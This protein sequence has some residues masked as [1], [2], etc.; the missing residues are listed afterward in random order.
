MLLSISLLCISQIVSAVLL[1]NETEVLAYQALQATAS[2]PFLQELLSIQVANS[3]HVKAIP[4]LFSQQKGVVPSDG[5]YQ[6]PNFGALTSWD[7]ILETLEH[8]ADQRLLILI[9]HGQ[10]YENL[11]PTSNSNCEFILDGEIIQNFDSPLSPEGQQQVQ[12]LND[13]FRSPVSNSSDKTWFETVGLAQ[14]TSNF[15]TSPLSRTMQTTEGAFSQLPLPSGQSFQ[16]HELIR[17]SVGVDVCNFRHSVKTPTSSDVLPAPWQTGCQLPS[18]SLESLF[19][20]SPKVKFAFSVR[21]AGGTGFGL[22]SDND[23][24][25]RSDV[26]D[27]AVIN[28]RASAFLSQVF[29]YTPASSVT[30]VV[31]H[32]EMISAIYEAAGEIPYSAKNTQVVPLMLRFHA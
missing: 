1:A 4:G 32:G 29:A 26:A 19:G 12:D 5:E 17:A 9:R 3:V 7:D 23:Q 27:S 13:L 24:L 11:N 31:T 18:D 10:A 21:P 6:L 30:A 22:V 14:D 20:S 2:L 15:V 28:T 16:V 25:W 8:S